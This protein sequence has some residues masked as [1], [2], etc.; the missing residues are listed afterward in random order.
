MNNRQKAKHFKR[1]YERDKKLE[2]FVCR[3][4]TPRQMSEPGADHTR[5]YAIDEITMHFKRDIAA[6]YVRYNNAEKCYEMTLWVKG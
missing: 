1:L 2:K 5:D 6:N 3:V 4:H